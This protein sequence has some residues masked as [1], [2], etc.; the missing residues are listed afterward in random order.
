[1]TLLAVENLS[2]S[3][4]KTS[5]VKGVSFALKAGKTLCL[6]GESGSGK[7]LSAQAIMG[8]LPDEMKRTSKAL[9]FADQNLAQLTEKE[10]QTLRGKEIGMVFQEPLSSLNPVMKVG[11]QVAEVFKIHTHLTKQERFDQV[12]KLFK[13]VK[14]DNPDQR[15]HQYPHELSGGQRQRVMIAMAIAL[16]P[17]LLIADE[18]TT[19]LD[20]SVQGEILKLLRNLQKDLGMAILFITHDFGVVEQLADHVV[21]LE[22]G[23]LVE[24]GTANQVINK[25][26]HAYTKKLLAARPV[27]APKASKRAK[28]DILTASKLNKV[29]KTGG[30]WGGA[31]SHH[32]LK[33]VSFSLKQGETLGIV[34]ESGC[35]KST[36]AKCLVRLENLNSGT[37]E[38]LGENLATAK[39]GKLKTLRRDIQMVFQD[40]FASLNPRMTVGESIVEGL[41]AHR[42]QNKEERAKTVAQLLKDVG[43]KAA[44]ATRYPHQFSGGQ[45]QR[46]CIARALALKPKLIIADE[47]TSALDVSI[48]KQVLEVLENLKEKYGLSYLFISHDLRV[49]S[50]ICDR[51]LVM[52]NGKIVEQGTA[53]QVFNTPK[54]AYTQKLLAAIPGKKA[55]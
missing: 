37:M 51:V 47:A 53:K 34:G 38:F 8:L 24:Q 6:V 22:K 49:I 54:Q 52:R 27:V 36:L 21:V 17:K 4:D 11:E 39:G 14:L 28:E 44:D 42:L 35:G 30:M 43:L 3:L 12:V 23:K 18:P 5:L 9:S 25:P 1:M 7:T 10:W 41:L 13:K 45:R 40:P 33:D 32:A 29:Y 15:F 48:Q 31:R 19:A 20:V 46:I 16:K 55:A 26:K 2:I 50:Q